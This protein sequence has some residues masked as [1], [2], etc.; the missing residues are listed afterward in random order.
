MYNNKNADTLLFLLLF[1]MGQC[2]KNID[3]AFVSADV[4]KR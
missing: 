2:E 1:T 4:Q 3:K